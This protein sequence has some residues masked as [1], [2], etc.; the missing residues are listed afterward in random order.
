MNFSQRSQDQQQSWFGS[1]RTMSR[2]SSTPNDLT[3][4]EH[5]ELEARGIRVV[6]GTVSCLVIDNDRLTGVE[7]VDGQ[8]IERSAVFI[9][10]ANTPH[11]DGLLAGLGCEVDPAGFVTGRQDRI[12][13]GRRRAGSC[14]TLGARGS[15]RCRPTRH[16][17]RVGSGCLGSTAGQRPA[18]GD[19]PA[20]GID[21]AAAAERPPRSRQ[22]RP[23]RVATRA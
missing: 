11:P 22:H 14:P 10:P 15:P 9:R 21:P 12:D 13:H 6:F 23:H 17:S 7:L 16:R 1:G 4:P 20:D 18:V 2:S 19:S 5:D 8:L 3:A